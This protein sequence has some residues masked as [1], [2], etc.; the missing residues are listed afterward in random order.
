LTLEESA[1]V[2]R[3]VASAGL[4][5][6]G[7]I[8]ADLRFADLFLEILKVTQQRTVVVVTSGNTTFRAGPR[9]VLLDWILEQQD[10]LR[11]ARR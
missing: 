4:F 5:D 8:G 1:D 3:M 7:H 2:R 10:T 6:G 9:K 11:K